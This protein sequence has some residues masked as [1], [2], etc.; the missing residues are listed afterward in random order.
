MSEATSVILEEKNFECENPKI[1]SSWYAAG[2][3]SL[4]ERYL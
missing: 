2:A 3:T 1:D 4:K